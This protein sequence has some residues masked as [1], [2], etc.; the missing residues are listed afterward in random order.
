MHHPLLAPSSYVPQEYRP[1]VLCL[2]GDLEQRTRNQSMA[3]FRERKTGVV[4][5]ST[6]VASRGLD[7]KDIDIVVNYEN[8]A[9]M[10]THTH[11]IGRTGRAG[12]EGLA[13]TLLLAGQDGLFLQRLI[14]HQ[15]KQGLPIPLALQPFHQDQYQEQLTLFKQQIDES[16]QSEYRQASAKLSQS[17]HQG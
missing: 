11:R 9:K 6:D 13:V 4:M 10:D 8:S 7:V 15:L 14:Q 5:V 16:K 17:L 1:C 12:E 3:D 2:H